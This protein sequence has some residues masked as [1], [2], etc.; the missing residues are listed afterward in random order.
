M[1]EL[2]DKPEPPPIPDSP[3]SFEAN[4]HDHRKTLEAPIPGRTKSVSRR[5]LEAL[6]PTTTRGRSRKTLEAPIPITPTT[7]NSPGFAEKGADFVPLDVPGRGSRNGLLGL[8]KRTLVL[9]WVVGILMI[10][11]LSLGLG[12][13]LGLKGLQTKDAGAGM[14]TSATLAPTS[15]VLATSSGTSTPASVSATESKSGTATPSA[16]T[17]NEPAGRV[18]KAQQ[19]FQPAF[20]VPAD[21][22]TT[23]YTVAAA[24]ATSGIGLIDCPGSNNAIYTSGSKNFRKSCYTDFPGP[25][26]LNLDSII[27]NSL[28]KCIDA[29]ARYSGDKGKCSAVSYSA[30]LTQVVPQQ[31][32]NCWLKDKSGDAKP[33][34]WDQSSAV[35]VP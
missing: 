27:V 35:L 18:V 33:G 31:K 25:G 16:T 6:I 15:T 2:S 1:P 34:T 20:A 5:T 17:S 24:T 30:S 23:T 22:P 9:L 4:S 26:V 29:C 21:A 14:A 11:G 19:F 13:G 3:K 8:K 32:A 28:E 12:L 10:L 7:P